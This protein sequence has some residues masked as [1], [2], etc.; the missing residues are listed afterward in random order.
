M[1]FPIDA[2]NPMLTAPESVG[3][4]AAKLAKIDDVIQRQM[5]KGNLQGAVVAVSRRGK[6]IYFSAFGESDQ[7]AGKPMRRDNMF[8]MQSSTKPVTGVAAMIAM[9]RGLF[10][11]T[12]EVQKYLPGF[13]EIEV[14]VLKDPTDQDVSPKFVWAEPGKEVGFFTRL[15]GDLIAKWTGGYM[16]FVPE[17]RTVPASRPIT[18][19]DLL[20]HTAGLGT[21]GLGQAS[22]EWGAQMFDKGSFADQ[23]Y[24]LESYIAAVAQG[25]LDFQP[26]TRWAYSPT[27]GLDVVARIIEVTSG[28]AFNEFVQTNIFDP[29]DMHDTQWWNVLPEEKRARVVVR[30]SEGKDGTRSYESVA[31]PGDDRYFSGSVGLISTARDFLHFEQMLVNQGVLLGNR[32]LQEDSVRLMSTDHA[33]HLF[34][35]ES[36]GKAGGTGF[37]YTVEVTLDPAIAELSRSEGAFGWAGAFGTYSWTEPATQIAVVVMVQQASKELG[38]ELAKAVSEAVID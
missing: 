10:A 8:V 23:A 15:A 34:G 12:D 7:E 24:T 3:M 17:H 20:T 38:R 11:A 30:L 26:G 14:A 9:E 32:I 29:L 6:P 16:L 27:I 28:Q 33:G 5:D 1:A 21:Y 37:G 31:E 4:S 2:E 36:K 25:P 18:I 13:A 35:G 19:H 22:S